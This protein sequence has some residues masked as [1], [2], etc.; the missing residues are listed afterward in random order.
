MVDS[1]IFFECPYCDYKTTRKY[2]LQLHINRKNTCKPKED[3]SNI[4]NVKMT[5]SGCQTD[6]PD[7]KMTTSQTEAGDSKFK[8][9]K[10]GKMMSSSRSLSRH[11]AKCNGVDS[12]QCPICLV[13]FSHR[14]A[15]NRHMKTIN[16]TPA[17]N[18]EVQ[19]LRAE[20]QC[21]APENGEVEDLRAEID[22]LKRSKDFEIER[23]KD[24]INELVNII[25]RAHIE[26]STIN[27]RNPGFSEKTKKTIAFEQEWKCKICDIVLPPDYHVDHIVEVCVGGSNLKSNG[28]ALCV[29]CHRKKTNEERA[30]RKD[31]KA[32]L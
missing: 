5:T 23:L 25:K 21:T 7:V 8:C 3:E 22:T 6:Q 4:Q 32:L 26:D 14:N 20:V 24:M 16:C 11:E 31:V 12:L 2:N 27:K 9:S 17:V 29:G 15:K 18:G 1:G 13:R 19:E 30:K 28:Q 10:C